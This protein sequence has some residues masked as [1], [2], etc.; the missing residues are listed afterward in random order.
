[1][2]IGFSGVI[3]TRA[4][5]ARSSAA[6]PTRASSITL[7]M[8]M[9]ILATRSSSYLTFRSVYCNV[10]VNQPATLAQENGGSRM[11]RSRSRWV[12]AAGAALL[13]V[14]A[15]PGIS[16]TSS[17]A[18]L[19]GTV[20]DSSGAVVPGVEVTITQVET[21]AARA[22][23]SD[24]NGAYTLGFLPPGRYTV[25]FALPGF[26]TLVREGVTL[27]VTETVAVD[28][29]MAVSAQEQEVTVVADGEILQTRTSTLGRVVDSQQITALPLVTRNF[30]QLTALSPGSSISLPDSLAVGNGSQN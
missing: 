6:A 29:R 30:T 10:A 3:L 1:M 5:P 16:Q 21:S 27:N 4:T 8:T 15:R 9:E 18:A 24:G 14:T 19:T 23:Q 22:T 20:R 2:W 28:A 17:T 12:L 25:K 13:L 7:A 11:S 26:K